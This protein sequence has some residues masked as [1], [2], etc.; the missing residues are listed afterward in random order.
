M[1]LRSGLLTGVLLLSVILTHAQ[2]PVSWSNKSGVVTTTGN[3]VVK[4]AADGWGNA[5]A[6]SDN[7]FGLLGDYVEYTVTETGLRFAFGISHNDPNTNYTST[8]Y[9]FI[10]LA[11]GQFNIIE[12]GSYRILSSNYSVGDVFRIEKTLTSLVYKRNGITVRSYLLNISL[13]TLKI[14]LSIYSNGNSIGGIKSSAKAP[15][16][17]NAGADQTIITGSS[18]AIG[19]SP[20]ARGGATPY[21]YA[22]SP[23][24]ALTASTGSNP[25]ASPT[26]ST[27]YE[28]LITDSEG[29]TKS[30]GVVVHVVP[31]LTVSAGRDTVIPKGD[32]ITIG[33]SPTAAGGIT[34]YTYL[35]TPADGLSS[36]T[37]PNPNA[38]PSYT[39]TYSVKVTDNAG[40]TLSDTVVVGVDTSI[41][42]IVRIGNGNQST[43]EYPFNG[44][45]S[46]NWSDVIYL[47]QELGVAGQIKYISLYVDN[48]P[49]HYLMEDQS[50][51]IRYT[52][53]LHPPN[54]YPDTSHFR[55]VYRGPITYNGSSWKKIELETPFNYN[56]VDNLE[57]LFVNNDS[58]SSLGAPAFRYT[59]GANSDLRTSYGESVSV[60]CSLSCETT[61]NITDVLIGLDID[62]CTIN[63]GTVS[64]PPLFDCYGIQTLTLSGQDPG[65]SLQWE[66]SANGISFRQ[67]TDATDPYLELPAE[68]LVPEYLRVAVTGSL[69]GCTKYSNAVMR[70]ITRLPSPDGTAVIT[71]DN[72]DC[73]DDIITLTLVGQTGTFQKWQS[74]VNG[75]AWNDIPGGTINPFNL[76]VFTTTSF[77]AVTAGSTTCSNYSS[78]AVHRSSNNYYVNDSSLAGDIYTSASG[79]AGNN[80]LSADLPKPSL[81]NIIEMYDLGPCDTVFVDAGSY[82]EAVLFSSED[83]G[84]LTGYLTILGAG[85]DL[86]IMSTYQAFDNIAL[87]AANYIT[88]QKLSLNAVQSGGVSQGRYNIFINGGNN[89]RIEDCRLSNSNSSNIFIYGQSSPGITAGNNQIKSCLITN[90]S[91]D[92]KA[93]Q[94]IG[95]CE[96][97]S[98]LN[99]TL[100]ITGPG[101]TCAIYVET[102]YSS[103]NLTPQAGLNLHNSSISSGDYGIFIY[104]YGRTIDDVSIL[105]NKIVLSRSDKTEGA[106]VWIFNTGN[107]AGHRTVISRNEIHGGRYGILSKYNANFTAISNNYISQSETGLFVSPLSQPL[108]VKSNFNEDLNP[109]ISPENF[110]N[111]L[112]ASPSSITG[113]VPSLQNPVQNELYFNSLFN[114]ISCLEFTQSSPVTWRVIN[115]ILYVW[116]GSEANTCLSSENMSS[117]FDS[118]NYNLYYN[119][120]GANSARF[121]SNYYSTLPEWQAE[122]H[123]R[124]ASGDESSVS[125]DPLYALSLTGNLDILLGS[126]AEGAGGYIA[127]VGSD[128]RNNIRSNPP[129]I[130]AKENAAIFA[131]AGNDL[132]TCAGVGVQLSGAGGGSYSWSPAGSLSDPAIANPVAAP[133]ATTTYTLTVTY[134][135]QTSTD[136]VVV[137]V[138]NYAVDAGDDKQICQGDD[139][140]LNA[141]GNVVS[142]SWLPAVGLSCTSCPSPLASPTQT[143]TYTLTGQGLPGCQATSQVVVSVNSLPVLNGAGQTISNDIC[144]GAQVTL[145]NDNIASG[146]TWTPETGLLNSG[147]S[148]PVASPTVT[149]SYTFTLENA[150][151]CKAHKYYEVNVTDPPAFQQLSESMTVCPSTKIVLDPKTAADQYTWT[152]S[153]TL[154]DG[155]LAFPTASPTASTTYTLQVSKNGCASVQSR[156]VAVNL[157]PAPDAR[158]TYSYPGFGVDFFAPVNGNNATYLW[159]F[160]DGDTGTG[161]APS[162]LYDVGWIYRVC[163]KVVNDCGTNTYCEDIIVK[164]PPVPCCN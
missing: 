20:T 33:G 67:I 78:V 52:D 107:N 26:S 144:R 72:N 46:F 117:L 14:D 149:T 122:K 44:N 55:L 141:S 133:T 56:G 131:N 30:D 9:G 1:K 62:K 63:T 48:N 71:S 132:Q 135:L 25:V 77:R 36:A 145:V 16:L 75:S 112:L 19:G 5:G 31:H 41:V 47:R 163:L 119:P 37:E 114:P 68:T 126:P 129:S 11:G 92:A 60:P 100:D 103:S 142:Y 138:I 151:G 159:D 42:R 17:A 8:E 93:V 70:A 164:D 115:N 29:G 27:T 98:F 120:N 35:W 157:Y 162:H 113:L 148:S 40:N 86:S 74:S 154:D 45:T 79:E 95:D 153:S 87:Q 147:I 158:F 32:T 13:G 116:G 69:P 34:P 4:T 28:V 64:T 3:A 58:S 81:R 128:I 91:A 97:T 152:P 139:V 6:F 24:T 136:Q 121:G 140:Q 109:E 7:S 110:I 57:I 50:I 137:T 18:V 146:F 73:S 12:S 105:S 22:W 43:S 80:G 83:Q 106:G 53:S 2:Y 150:A 54:S 51:F 90:T 59:A 156:T 125:S 10:F 49:V 104:G 21:G 96:Q 82:S 124:S 160:G 15:L 143:T 123:A 101:E 108:P 111:D 155:M 84:G 134:G 38:S 99:D 66:T 102:N 39:T 130:G 127:A 23:S 65:V 76:R 61:G 88:I 89:N 85:K 118:C 94:V 161:A